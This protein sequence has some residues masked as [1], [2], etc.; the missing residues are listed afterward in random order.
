[1]KKSGDGEISRPEYSNAAAE[2]EYQKLVFN[3]EL[4]A[5]AVTAVNGQPLEAKN[6]SPS[7]IKEPVPTIEE[8]DEREFSFIIF[9]LILTKLTSC[10]III[11]L[12]TDSLSLITQKSLNNSCK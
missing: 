6:R 2:K 9:I 8:L 7:P 1:M 11:N 3:P 5:T 12:K 10:L 4:F